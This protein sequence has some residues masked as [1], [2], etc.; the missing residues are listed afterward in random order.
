MSLHGLSRMR[1]SL[2]GARCFV[3][4][5]RLQPLDE[6][7]KMR[8]LI[9]APKPLM[10]KEEHSDAKPFSAVPGPF[11]L[12]FLGCVHR[13][14]DYM[15]N[16]TWHEGLFKSFEKYGPIYKENIGPLNLV[17]IND[18]DGVEKLHRQEGKYPRRA[19]IIPWRHWRDEQD[20]SRGILTEDG[21]EWKRMRSVLDKQMLIPRHVA[22]YTEDFNEVVTDFIERLRQIRK[23]GNGLAVPNLDHEL[24]HWSLETIGTVLY[25]TRLGG[26]SE[27]RLPE[28]TQF[29]KAVQDLFVSL[30]RINFF[31]VKLN[32]IILRKW[33]KLHDDCWE[34]IFRTTQKLVTEKYKEIQT[35]LEKDKAV[36]GFLPFLLAADLSQE[37]VYANIA[38]I[39]LGAV[40]TTSNTMQWILY[41][42]SRNATLQEELHDEVNRVV[43]FGKNP[44]YDDLQEMP[45]LRAMVKEALRLYPVTTFT[46]RVLNEEIVLC[47]YR[48]PAEATVFATLYTLGRD[49]KNFSD[50]LTFK[51]ERWLRKDNSETV[52]NFSWLPFGFGPRSCIGRRVAELEMHLLLARISQSFILT[53]ADDEIRRSVVRGLLVP[54]K[55]VF[56]NFTDRP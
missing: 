22:T 30:G 19:I 9:T 52:H 11:A 12:P 27:N 5:R 6:R 29:V 46:T 20:L 39:M 37:E 14:P 31:P 42:L 28:T 51:P 13:T 33:Q 36:S 21:S 38:E 2:R 55:P 54:H 10:D 18:V 34:T 16:E 47:G 48:V 44:T 7:R 25:E 24:F 8:Y 15:L 4:H 50:P 35:K 26:L 23:R 1:Q 40:D 49:P 3:L 17:F 56:L 45:L 32:R 53:P 41:E 43:P